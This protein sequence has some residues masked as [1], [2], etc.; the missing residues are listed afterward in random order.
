MMDLKKKTGG[1]VIVMTSKAR[2]NDPQSHP[3]F[4]NGVHI[5]TLGTL[6]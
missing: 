1:G 5:T 4:T 3:W 6:S 2:Q